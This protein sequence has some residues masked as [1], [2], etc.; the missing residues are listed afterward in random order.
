MPRP[1]GEPNDDHSGDGAGVSV[2][3]GS[4]VSNILGLN[5]L[6]LWVQQV[7]QDGCRVTDDRMY[8]FHDPDA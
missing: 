1:H 7:A 2:G 3:A 4:T 8:P 6:E 5:A